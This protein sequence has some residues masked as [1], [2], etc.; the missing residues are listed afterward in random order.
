MLIV[1]SQRTLQIFERDININEEFGVAK[2][3]PA[4]EIVNTFENGNISNEFPECMIRGASLPPALV[5]D[6]CNK[7]NVSC[8]MCDGAYLHEKG[9]K[10]SAAQ[11]RSVDEIK[12]NLN[13]VDHIK[14]AILSGTYCEPLLNPEL[15]E[16]ISFL[17]TKKAS[18][19]VI[20][21]G[22]LINKVAQALINVRLDAIYISLHGAS[23]QTA[24]EIMRNTNFDR[25]ISNIR[26]L[27]KLKKTHGTA[28]PE[29]VI[30]FVGMRRNISE[31]SNLVELMSQIGV[32][33]VLVKSLMERQKQGLDILKNESLV[34]HRE[35]LREEYQRAQIIAAK[36]NVHLGANEPYKTII[37]SKWMDR[38]PGQAWSKRRSRNSSFSILPIFTR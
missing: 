29:V 37:E 26:E 5:F 33:K 11:Y 31:L 20:S 7:C 15:I 36:Y 18:V 8:I 23:K 1:G 14:K 10:R 19:E 13:G 3:S 34:V 6:V 4:S 16:I 2:I 32:K 24:E 17:K 30:V 38:R 21:N 35:L 12:K 27:T 25:V 9:K 22:T 28:L